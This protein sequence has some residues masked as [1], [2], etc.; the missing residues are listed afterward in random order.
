MSRDGGAGAVAPAGRSAGA[1]LGRPEVAANHLDGIPTEPGDLASVEPSVAETFHDGVHDRKRKME[2]EAL[3]N[4]GANGA[5]ADVVGQAPASKV[6][7]VNGESAPDDRGRSAE[8]AP[9]DEDDDDDDE[10]PTDDDDDELVDPPNF[11][12]A[13]YDKVS[14]IKNR[15]RCQLK[16]GIFHANGKDYLFK[17]ATG[18]FT[19]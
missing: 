5:H 10:L 15:W 14:R 8:R 12:T 9:R 13:Q 17:N 19:F 3:E 18:D 11:L 6:Q 7:R 16:Y 4:G 1:D 2:D